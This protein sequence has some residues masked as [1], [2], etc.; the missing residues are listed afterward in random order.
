M[1]KLTLE[2]K[3]EIT[4]VKIVPV[5]TPDYGFKKGKPVD[6]NPIGLLISIDMFNEMIDLYNEKYN[7]DEDEKYKLNV[8]ISHERSIENHLNNERRK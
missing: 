5:I 4:G 6:G 2:C 3:M 7:N 1:S 8:K